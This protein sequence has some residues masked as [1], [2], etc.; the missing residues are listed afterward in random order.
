MHS[1]PGNAEHETGKAHA[2]GDGE[3]ALR[4]SRVTSA[5][6]DRL[7]SPIPWKLASSC[8]LLAGKVGQFHLLLIRYLRLW[9]LRRERLCHHE[10]RERIRGIPDDALSKQK[11]LSPRRF[12]SFTLSVIQSGVTMYISLISFLE[13]SV[14]IHSHSRFIRA[15]ETFSAT[16]CVVPVP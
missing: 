16:K 7:I 2:L 14:M 5:C 11:A 4:Y 13:F 9:P 10:E 8:R 15:W 6:R 12:P 3:L 1:G